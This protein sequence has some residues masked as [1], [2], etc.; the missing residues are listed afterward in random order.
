MA[1][2]L[3]GLAQLSSVLTFLIILVLNLISMQSK[4]NY[5]YN[6]IVCTKQGDVLV[7]AKFF[8]CLWH[9]CPL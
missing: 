2:I 4:E 1:Q 6:H 7:R 5:K 8:Q 3:S 9:I